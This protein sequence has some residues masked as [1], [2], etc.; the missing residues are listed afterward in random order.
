MSGCGTLKTDKG[1][2]YFLLNIYL[3]PSCYKYL[4]LPLLRNQ[5]DVGLSDANP[6]LPLLPRLQGVE[7]SSEL[8]FYVLD[9][10]KRKYPQT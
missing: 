1:E 8:E 2:T 9:H 6:I 4:R 3:R 7:N 10:D 5:Q